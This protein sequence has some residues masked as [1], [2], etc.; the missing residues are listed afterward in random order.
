[1]GCEVKKCES[2]VGK[3]TCPM[4][5]GH[6]NDLSLKLFEEI[7]EN[8]ESPAYVGLTNVDR[9]FKAFERL[10]ITDPSERVI[11]AFHFGT[12]IGEATAAHKITESLF[13][14][15]GILSDPDTAHGMGDIPITK[16]N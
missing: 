11:L 2:C 1:M 6:L 8:I 14:V 4:C 12:S 16:I 7:A 15:V 13:G 10:G 9:L 3:K 5:K